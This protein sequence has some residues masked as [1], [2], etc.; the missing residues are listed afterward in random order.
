MRLGKL[1][2]H[3]QTSE[4][5]PVYLAPL[6]KINSEWI[7]D[8]N[9]KSKMLKLVGKKKKTEAEPYKITIGIEHTTCPGIMVIN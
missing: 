2:A 4:I 3:T 9:L 6:K 5:R 1:G 8:V 7:K